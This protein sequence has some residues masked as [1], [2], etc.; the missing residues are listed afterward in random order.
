[1]PVSTDGIEHG[2]HNLNL[3]SILRVAEAFD[4]GPSELFQR[5]EAAGEPR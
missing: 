3:V 4:I 2:E 1:M 5:F